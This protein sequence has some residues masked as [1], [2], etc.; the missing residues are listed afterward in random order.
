[1]LY[2]VRFDS[3]AADQLSALRRYISTAATPAM[4]DNYLEAVLTHC[5]K[6]GLFPHA[7]ALRDDIRPGLRITTYKKRVTIAFTVDDPS[8]TI[9]VLGVYYGGQDLHALSITDPQ[10]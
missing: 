3:E 6:L 7:A 8:Q 4:A 10:R 1:M 5:Q 2:Q 9:T